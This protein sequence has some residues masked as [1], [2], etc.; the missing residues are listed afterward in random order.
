MIV[1]VL[2]KNTQHS[3]N[4]RNVIKLYGMIRMVKLID[5]FNKLKSDYEKRQKQI[6]DVLD[7]TNKAMEAHAEGME[8]MK[9]SM[10]RLEDSLVKLQR[11]YD[12][13]YIET[14]K[15]IDNLKNN[16]WLKLFGV[17]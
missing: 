3:F 6:D 10:E 4:V 7:N 16:Y 2:W 15:Y 13:F 1:C 9:K 12:D 11:D 14:K 5:L 17:K 8:A